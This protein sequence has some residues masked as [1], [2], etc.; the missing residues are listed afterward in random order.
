M[1]TKRQETVLQIIV[2]DYIKTASPIASDRIVRNNDLGVSPATIRNDVAT[3]EDAGYITRPHTSAGSVPL[4]KA[5]RFYVEAQLPDE[6]EH[7]PLRARSRMRSQLSEVEQDVDVWATVAAELLAELAGN[8]AVATFP[9]SKESRVKHLELV[10]LQDMLLMLI[11]VLGQARLRRQLIRLEEPLNPSELEATTN[12]MNAQLTG[13]SRR[14]INAKVMDLT[15]FEKD[16]A[17]ATSAILMEEEKAAY[18]DHYVNGLRNLL[19]QPEF[20]E[21]EKMRSVVSGVEDG[22]LIEAIL[23]EAPE[24]RIVRVVIG[25][26][27]DGDLLWPMSI[28]ICQYGIPDQAVGAVGIIGPTR[29]EYPKAIS[30]V[31]FMSALMSDLVEQA[32]I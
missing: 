29:M 11:V 23:K 25:Q 20:S 9:R 32:N 17:I 19:N 15:P 26:E 1:I 10:P 3:L 5:Y 22:S 6:I 16:L 27:N 30:G 28:V 18:R 14:E 8:M 21:N 7:I 4:D 2:D 12:K 24:G 31:K 13:L